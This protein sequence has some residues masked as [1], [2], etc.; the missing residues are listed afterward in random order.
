M[1]P[2]TLLWFVIATCVR[3]RSIALAMSFS[4]VRIESRLKRVWM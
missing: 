3:P 2:S 4:S 1:A